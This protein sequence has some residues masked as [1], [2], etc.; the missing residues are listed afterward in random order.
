MVYIFWVWNPGLATISY[1]HTNKLYSGFTIVSSF[2][3]AHRIYIFE[4][5]YDIQTILRTL[6]SFFNSVGKDPPA[7]PG[8]P[9]VPSYGDGQVTYEHRPSRHS[10]TPLSGSRSGQILWIRGLTRL[11]TQVSTLFCMFVFS[12]L[13]IHTIQ[14]KI[15]RHDIF[16]N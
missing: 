7:E 6:L 10:D 11:Q 8:S 15:I 13:I 12:H 3:F 1:I 4:K 16:F 2:L 5:Y 14:H 9:M